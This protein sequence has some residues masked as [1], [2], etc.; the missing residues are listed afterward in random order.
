MQKSEMKCQPEMLVIF[1]PQ[2]YPCLHLGVMVRAK[3]DRVTF[4]TECSLLT[5]VYA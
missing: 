4:Q 2:H 3:D 5:S 1:C